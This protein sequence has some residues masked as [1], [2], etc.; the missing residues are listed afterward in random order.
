MKTIEQLQKMLD[1]NTP[2]IYI[3]NHDFVRVDELIEEAIGSDGEIL[4]WNPA[5]GKTDFESKAPTLYDKK[6]L[7]LNSFLEEIYDPTGNPGMNRFIVLKEIQDQIDEP[8]IRT[9]LMLI[10]QRRL[11]DSGIQEGGYDLPEYRTTIIIVSS[12]NC[13]PESLAPYV[14][15]LEEDYPD[16]KQI[17]ELIDSHLRINR[18]ENFQDEDRQKL[19]PSLKG[20]TAFEIDRTLDM[21]MS[22]NGILRAND[23]ELILRQKFN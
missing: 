13:V 5:T 4:E 14:S 23:Q 18:D 9:L 8:S 21:A 20:L 1:V 2:I 11:Y 10:A 3:Q 6:K 12:V 16:E 15:Y 7:S 22:S 19:L 17:N